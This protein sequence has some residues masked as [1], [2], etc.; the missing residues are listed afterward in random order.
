MISFIGR[1][2]AQGEDD[3][4]V[5][6]DSAGTTRITTSCQ[7]ATYQGTRDGEAFIPGCK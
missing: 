7:S 3:C 4:R 5:E 1:D 2:R 6:P